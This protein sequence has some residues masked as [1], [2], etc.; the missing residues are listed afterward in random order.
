MASEATGGLGEAELADRAGVPVAFVRRAAE[1]GIVRPA[2][3]ERPYRES[4]LSR[5]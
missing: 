4:D 3:A 2:D 5:V 1:L